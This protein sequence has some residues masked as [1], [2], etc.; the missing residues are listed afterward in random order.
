VET[1]RNKTVPCNERGRPGS[2]DGIFSFLHMCDERESFPDF[3]DWSNNSTI[4]IN[5]A[6]NRHN[7]VYESTKFQA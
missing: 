4:K 7:F 6:V 1:I 2:S 5:G 3:I